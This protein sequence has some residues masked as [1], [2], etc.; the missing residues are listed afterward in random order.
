MNDNIPNRQVKI[1]FLY[2]LQKYMHEYMDEERRKF[3][4]WTSPAC[5]VHTALETAATRGPHQTVYE[6]DMLL[7]WATANI[8]RLP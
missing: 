5:V 4:G 2:Y 6:D 1:S 3:Q 7:D 8:D